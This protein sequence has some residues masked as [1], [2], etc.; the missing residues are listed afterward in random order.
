MRCTLIAILLALCCAFAQARPLSVLSLQNPEAERI[1]DAIVGAL[2][3]R[4]TEPVEDADIFDMEV[5]FLDN[6]DQVAAT[7]APLAI[8]DI[9]EAF[10]VKVPGHERDTK[11]LVM[12]EEHENDMLSQLLAKLH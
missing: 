9:D 12:P 6:P 7:L 4:S 11:F 1:R 8:P 3:E 10:L 2:I 5:E